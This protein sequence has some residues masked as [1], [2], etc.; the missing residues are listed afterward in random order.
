MDARFQGLVVVVIDRGSGVGAAAAR[1]FAAEGASV[2]I[3]G[4]SRAVLDHAEAFDPALDSIG[5]TLGRVAARRADVGDSSTI[6]D[7]LDDVVSRYG[8][9]DV[10]VN[11]GGLPLGGGAEA[12][13]PELWREILAMELDATFYACRAAIGHLRRTAG[14]IVNVA[15]TSGVGEGRSV[16]STAAFAGALNLTRAMA[17]DHGP[18]GVRVNAVC[19]VLSGEEQDDCASDA[20]GPAG[21]KQWAAVSA[22][23]VAR[24]AHPT[25]V[26]DVVVFLASED[27]R[28]VNGVSVPVD[29]GFIDPAPPLAP[30]HA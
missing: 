3:A 8:R 2:V 11:S 29:G 20:P 1:R 12:T 30:G 19:S 9:L 28:F 27:A 25:E 6:T 22:Y 4:A 5:D 10:L 23:R 18:E 14:S 21:P 15:S 26:A 17:L 7:L 16:G 13:T 24:P